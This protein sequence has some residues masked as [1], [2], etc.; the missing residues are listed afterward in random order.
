MNEEIENIIEKIANTMIL[1]SAKKIENNDDKFLVLEECSLALN[2]LSIEQL[3]SGRV[4]YS[5]LTNSFGIDTGKFRELCG[6]N[7]SKGQANGQDFRYREAG[8]L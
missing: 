7:Y 5:R 1:K 3:Q 2:D 8:H 4:K 6:A